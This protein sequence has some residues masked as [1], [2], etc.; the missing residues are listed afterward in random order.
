[1][2]TA[3]KGLSTAEEA[4]AR[5]DFVRRIDAAAHHAWRSGLIPMVVVVNKLSA[6]PQMNER[7]QPTP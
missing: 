2:G 7:L 5:V 3:A 1:L 6:G 4:I